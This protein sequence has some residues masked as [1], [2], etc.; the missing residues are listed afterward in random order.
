MQD[1]DWY[2]REYNPRLSPELDISTAWPARAAATRAKRPPVADIR[3]GTH[4]R[5]T[6]DLFRAGHAKGTVVFI[7]GGFW[8]VS[9]KDDMSWI[10]E[11][12]LDDG[13]SVALLNYPL[14]PEVSLEALI[15]SVRQS[16]AKLRA[17]ILSEAERAAMVVTGHS[18]G[19][20]L[21]A[22]FVT[23]DWTN[24]GLPVLP[25]DG[26]VAISGIFELAPLIMT[27]H[28][29]TLKLDHER[30][31]RLSLA[32]AR[33]Q[34]DVPVTLVVG[35]AES[36]E[37]QRQSHALSRAWAELRTQVAV[38]PGANHYSIVRDLAQRGSELN[39]IVLT[40]LAERH[41]RAKR[42]SDS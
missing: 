8:R 25:F 29:R 11:G 2:E 40:M 10:A 26:V 22:A 41:G 35:E 12:F 1:G 32:A 28:N 15:G 21:A 23:T 39:S 4:P 34:V 37:F 31:A 36:S 38:I 30:A 9:S 33:P 7:H 24:F 17:E 14:C 13:Y 18:A 5:E 3:T 19:G 20:Y 27:T 6:L 42:L 16:F